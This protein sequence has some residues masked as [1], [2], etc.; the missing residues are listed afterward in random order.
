MTDSLGFKALLGKL[1][2]SFFFL[3]WLKIWQKASEGGRLLLCSQIGKVQSISL[4]SAWQQVCN[5]ART[6][7]YSVWA[8]SPWDG[9]TNF[10]KCFPSSFN[11]PWKHLQR[12]VQICILLKLNSRFI[13]LIKINHHKS[14][15]RNFSQL[16]VKIYVIEWQPQKAKTITVSLSFPS[17]LSLFL[18]FFNFFYVIL[19]YIISPILLLLVSYY[20]QSGPHFADKKNLNL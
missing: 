1:E 16:P 6:S 4:E 9:A 12:H 10:R 11:P 7:G 19:F 14:T 3:L 20:F 17:S 2:D 15:T 8:P 13:Y 18:S 5:A